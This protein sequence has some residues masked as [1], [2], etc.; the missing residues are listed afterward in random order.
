[1]LHNGEA[2]AHATSQA[3]VRAHPN[4]PSAGFAD[5]TKPIYRKPQTSLVVNGHLEH[6]KVS[7]RFLYYHVA[8]KQ[9]KIASQLQLVRVH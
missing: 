6:E 3:Y 7:E 9:V 5:T 8:Y 2:A 4:Q 1:M